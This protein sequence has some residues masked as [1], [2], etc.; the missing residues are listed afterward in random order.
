VDRGDGG[1]D[2]QA[3]PEPVVRRAAVEP[4]ER[5]EDAA[6]VGR[7]DDRAGIGDGELA[8][9]RD[10]AGADPDVAAWMVVP[11]RVVDQVRDEV[12]GEHR[13]AGDDGG[14]Q[15][16][17][18]LPVARAGRV[19][20]VFGNRGQVGLLADG[21]PA[22]VAREEEQRAD[23]VLGVIDRG[24]DVRRHAAQVGLRAVRVVQHDVDGGAHDRERGAQFVGGVGDEPLLALERGLEPAEHRVERLGQLPQFVAGT[25]RRD[26]RR[27][28]VFRRGAGGLRDQVHRAQCPPGEDPAK[29]RGEGEDYRNS[30]Q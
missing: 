24:A 13:I 6:G 16:G 15:R 18:H 10:R 20:D 27:Q 23:E 7:R 2:G 3:E 19:E 25:C 28:V 9:S 29:H 8:A 12:L 22:L 21:E 14:L 26:P 4:L 30:D 17:V 1:D 5:L 11:D